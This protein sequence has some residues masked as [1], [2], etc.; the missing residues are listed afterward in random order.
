MIRTK[1]G[2]SVLG[3][4]GLALGLLALYAGSSGAEK[5]A[6]WMV[7]G[8]NITSNVL[9]PLVQ[10]EGI[11]GGDMTLIGSNGA[12][13]VEILCTGAKFIEAKLQAEGSISSG[14]TTRFTG[15]ITKFNGT[16]TKAC[17]PSTGG[18]KGV[19][20]SEPLKGLLVLNEGK[21]IIEFTP[22]TGTAFVTF[23]FGE[24]CALGTKVPVTGK[25]TVKESTNELGVEK[26]THLVEQ[27]PGSSL[28]FC[29]KSAVIQGSAVLGLSGAHAG[30]KWSGLPA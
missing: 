19:V 17:E 11:D 7:N 27:G 18:E 30:M 21:P 20:V 12:T 10:I 25:S 8:A 16:I 2:L 4:C 15:C 22:V 24:E 26:V 28:T 6:N 13:K 29:G 14:N 9:S 3:I 5:G 23:I 1:R